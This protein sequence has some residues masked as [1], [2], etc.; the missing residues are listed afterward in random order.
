VPAGPVSVT[1]TISGEAEM[2]DTRRF[3]RSLVA[4]VTVL[5][6]LVT[7]AGVTIGSGPAA[8]DTGFV[9]YTCSP[10]GPVSVDITGSIPA[11][12]NVGGQFS[13]SGFQVVVDL[14]TA[15]VQ[16]IE[17]GFGVSTLS[18][19]VTITTNAVGAT[20]SSQTT[21]VGTFSVNLPMP[22]APVSYSVP[23]SPTT[24]GPFTATAGHVVLTVGDG[25]LSFSNIGIAASCTP[26][27]PPP[28]LAA[29]QTVGPF[30]F[31][32][33]GG[34]GTVTVLDTATG[35]VVGSPIHVGGTPDYIA[36]TPDGSKALV[37]T[38]P[39]GHS[40]VPI[41]TATLTAGSPIPIE[42]P[43]GLAITPDGS[44]A[45]VAGGSAD[46]KL[47]PVNLATDKVGTPL[48]VD[49]QSSAASVAISPDGSTAYVSDQLG[50]LVPVD[51]TTET[52]GPAI[53]LSQNPSEVDIAPNGHTA[54][55]DGGNDLFPLDLTQHPP[56][57]GT[58]ITPCGPSGSPDRIAITP[59][60]ATAYVGC[61]TSGEVV[62]VNLSSFTAGT[63]ISI[64]SGTD[65]IVG[66]GVSPDGGTVYAVDATAGKVFP[67]ATATNTAGTSITV[68]SSPQGVG[69]MPDAGP[70]ASL[71]VSE[72]QTDPSGLTEDF[73]AGAS[74]SNTGAIA[75]YSWNFGDG[76]TDVT[77]VATDSHAYASSGSYTATVTETTAAGTSTSEISTGQE[78]LRNGNSAAT[79]SAHF[80]LAACS[81][82]C[83]PTVTSPDGSAT[84]AVTQNAS[85]QG[86]LTLS[87]APA[88]LGCTKGFTEPS[89]VSTLTESSQYSSSSDID[90]QVTETG[91]ASTSGVRV[92]YQS[93]GPFPPPPIFLKKCNSHH[94]APC[95]VSIV[96]S[97]TDTVQAT[98][99]VPPGD[100]RFWLGCGN[101]GL[102]TFSPTKAIVGAPVVIKGT[103]LSQ[104]AGVFFSAEPPGSFVQAESITFGSTTEITVTVP[105]GAVSGPVKVTTQLNGY[106]SKKT[107][108]VH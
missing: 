36:A 87:V 64:G 99:A 42:A 37:S 31:V 102:S 67:I 59:D 46:N 98:L 54:Y 79:S 73:D 4:G 108:K 97:G 66:M 74:V 23:S 7:I 89:E 6:G 85:T 72:D 25:T 39:G 76:H 41:D 28:V 44:T 53:T 78:I 77:T 48:T 88:I 95:Y 92:C 96:P 33:N 71:S 62:P 40:L 94:P 101:L 60:G 106:V 83:T 107:F 82:G 49:T 16:A 35:A 47:Y 86:S 55:V 80:T 15:Q 70:A 3:I 38:W 21:T 26:P 17:S 43:R 19:G 2:G 51:L 32:G 24:L 12:V 50:E 45:W 18:G 100:P 93:G 91:L 63:P 30:T 57:V 105:Q 11:T 9:S 1:V 13:V 27:S 10:G 61:F 5:G 22:A 34:A 29:T 69:I 104:V 103:N 20:P 14:T 56:V 52:V 68:G 84:V 8:A 65:Q 90:V 81:T 58:P 75:S